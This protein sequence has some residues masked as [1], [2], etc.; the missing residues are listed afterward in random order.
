MAFTKRSEA[1]RNAI[2]T[3]ARKLLTERGYDAM[4]IR[5]VAAAVGVDPSMVMRYYGSKAGLFSAAIDVDLRL[6]QLQPVSADRLGEAL[7]RHF[8]ARWEGELSDDAV[9]LL[10][11]SASTSDLAAE[12]VR[13]VFAT[14]ISAAFERLI[15]AG[16]PALDRRAALVSAH[17]LG[18][19]LSR[20]VLRFPPLTRLDVATLADDVAPVLQYYLTGDL[21][22]AV[23]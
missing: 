6:D 10:L 18:L 22:G 21:A 3:A 2:L 5:A 4:T 12:H 19:A 7:A 16:T 20:Y 17:L 1:T 9:M 14:Q 23:R 13:A 11:R 15:G 8:L